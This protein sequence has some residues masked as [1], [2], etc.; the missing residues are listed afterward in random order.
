MIQKPVLAAMAALASIASAPPA[1]ASI[2]SLAG[3]AWMA[4]NWHDTHEPQRSQER[5]ALAPDHVLM[6]AAWEFPADKA[7]YAELMT[8]RVNGDA[9]SMFLRHFD[10][11]LSKAWEERDAPMVFTAMSCE[12]SS[13]IFDG[14]GVH[15]GERLTY[16][17]SGDSLSIVGDFL[18]QGKPVRMEWHMSKASD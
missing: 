16:S 5:W 10:G 12:S 4:G 15:A 18:H 7:G 3:L 9:V 1:N 6:G 17:R 14:Q 2:C 11:A 13:A 8:V